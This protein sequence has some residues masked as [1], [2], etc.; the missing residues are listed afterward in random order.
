MPYKKYILALLVIVFG[1]FLRIFL[2]EKIG[3]PNLEPVTALSLMSGLFFGGIFS[4]FIPLS[5]IYLS[6]LYF[7]NNFIF[8]FTWSAFALI[9]IFGW[10][11][12]R[13]R[14][15][16]YHLFKILGAGILSAIF[17]YLWTNFG[18]W[19]TFKM[20]PMNFKGLIECYIAALPFFKNQL[21]SIVIFVPIFS[22]SLSFLF[23]F[24]K[25]KENIK[26]KIKLVEFLQKS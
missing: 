13:K 15:F 12:K 10:L 24:F 8:I 11:I 9:G 22:F 21:I 5:I 14:N 2:N 3:A 4:F 6:D 23:N 19:L 25:I 16:S 18:W 7:G 20:Y 26:D 17:F 1:V